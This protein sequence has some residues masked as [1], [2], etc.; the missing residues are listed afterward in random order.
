M[1][2][3]IQI[4]SGSQQGRCFR[5]AGDRILVGD[6]AVADV[7][8]DPQ[9]EAGARG[10]NA[11]LTLD[12]EEGWRISNVGAGAWLVNQ[13]AVE[14]SQTHRLRSEDLVRVS[15]AGPDFSFRIVAG[16]HGC[17][18]PATVAP[19]SSRHTPSA[20]RPRGDE[21]ADGT[22]TM[23]AF[24]A[25]GEE[26]T[27]RPREFVPPP[28]YGAP[29]ESGGP[30]RRFAETI[31]RVFRR[32]ALRRVGLS[33]GL[34]DSSVRVAGAATSG[35]VLPL[36][37][38]PDVLPA[39]IATGD[40]FRTGLATAMS[41]PLQAALT[42]AGT[43]LAWS[44][45]ASGRGEKIEKIAPAPR[46]KM[47]TRARESSAAGRMVG[48]FI[49]GLLGLACA[50]GIACWFGGQK[51]DFLHIFYTKLPSP[52][53]SLPMGEKSNLPSRRAPPAVPRAPTTPAVK[54]L[55]PAP[56]GGGSPAPNE[57]PNHPSR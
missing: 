38:T 25:G 10:K 24:N 40:E 23:Q 27:G 29:V 26:A 3:E 20:V 22:S 52:P 45:P 35:P 30:F 32:S 50:Y 5:F 15:E 12:D 46:P 4:L 1:A 33:T 13:T 8:F 28:S 9:C 53:A 41:S 34:P 55:H 49:S 6:V 47:R 48:V 31:A 56:P 37:P 17:A 44:S 14:S 43:M 39:E 2:V 11:I 21:T 42:P 7:R 36:G 16:P 57:T 19:E 51:N 18:I 54:A